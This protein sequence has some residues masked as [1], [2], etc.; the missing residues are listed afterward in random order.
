MYSTQAAVHNIIINVTYGFPY[1][2]CCMKFC[3][4]FNFADFGFSQEFH[5]NRFWEFGFQ[6]TQK[7]N[8]FQF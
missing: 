4:K 7:D 3:Q 5:K 1:I 2:L 6:T 8:A